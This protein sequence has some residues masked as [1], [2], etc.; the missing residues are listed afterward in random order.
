VNY[1]FCVGIWCGEPE[2]FGAHCSCDASEMSR[3]YLHT[4]IQIRA[5]GSTDLVF[6]HCW[7]QL[8]ALNFIS[9]A[10]DVSAMLLPVARFHWTIKI[11]SS[12]S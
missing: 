5:Y 6:K 11:F 7:H 8:F 12:T 9:T 10:C 4:F 1:D 2:N 3:V